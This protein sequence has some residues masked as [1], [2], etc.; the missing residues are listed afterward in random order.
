MN[1]RN[2]P[3][4]KRSFAY[5]YGA[6]QYSWVWETIQLLLSSWLGLQGLILAVPISDALAFLLAVSLL[7]FEMKEMP[8]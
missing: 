7:W 8:A 4:Q 3:Y 6:K 1:K 2:P 5:L